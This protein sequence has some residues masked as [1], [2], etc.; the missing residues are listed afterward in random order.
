MRRSR[1]GRPGF[2]RCGYIGVRADGWWLSS[3]D[4]SGL[5]STTTAGSDDYYGGES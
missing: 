5:S 2:L 4:D 3:G 1:D